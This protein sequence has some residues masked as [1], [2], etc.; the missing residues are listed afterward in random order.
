MDFYN[1]ALQ[2]FDLYSGDCVKSGSTQ[3]KIHI[4]M[5]ATLVQ[6]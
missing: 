2:W 5:T 3:V 1:I 4:I 6:K